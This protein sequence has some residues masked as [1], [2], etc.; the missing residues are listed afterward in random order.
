VILGKSYAPDSV[1][2]LGFENATKNSS[3]KALI[4][5]LPVEKLSA[6]VK[7]TAVQFVSPVK[8]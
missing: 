2:A 4:G 6:L 5:S 7:I 1:A 3:N 8:I